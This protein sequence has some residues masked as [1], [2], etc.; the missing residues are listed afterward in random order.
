M[1]HRNKYITKIIFRKT[2]ADM[3]VTLPYKNKNIAVYIIE[4]TI[5]LL[6]EN[7]VELGGNMVHVQKQHD[8]L[9]YISLVTKTRTHH[10]IALWCLMAPQKTDICIIPHILAFRLAKK[11]MMMSW[12]WNGSTYWIPDCSLVSTCSLPPK[13]SAYNRRSSSTEKNS[14]KPLEMC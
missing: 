9:R 12:R 5:V 8:V 6:K 1:K 4:K 2:N 11:P 14:L 10:H 13:S 3:K 7:V